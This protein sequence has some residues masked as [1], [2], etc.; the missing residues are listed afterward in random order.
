MAGG[1]DGPAAVA[2]LRILRF[3][4]YTPRCSSCGAPYGDPVSLRLSSSMTVNFAADPALVTHRK[5]FPSAK[6][7]SA[8]LLADALQRICT[9]NRA[10]GLP[11]DW[12]TTARESLMILQRLLRMSETA[13]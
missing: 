6:A 13:R 2:P 1:T 10:A 4:A 7:W 5:D 8:V 11:G 9:T 12:E 3:P